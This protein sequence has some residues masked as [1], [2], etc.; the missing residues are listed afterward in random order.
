V[1]A[2]VVKLAFEAVV[3]VIIAGIV[4]TMVC[5]LTRARWTR[6]LAL[7]AVMAASFYLCTPVRLLMK[8]LGI[9]VAPV[10]FSPLLTVLVL[11]MLQGLLVGP[12]RF[13]P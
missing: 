12:L 9:P 8:S 11:R 4:L 5:Q 7:R 13:L 10:D 6:H 1:T 2:F 3:L